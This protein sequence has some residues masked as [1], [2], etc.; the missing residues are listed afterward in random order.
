ME[1]P[2]PLSYS[3]VYDMTCKSNIDIFDDEADTLIILLAFNVLARNPFSKL[4]IYKP[5]TNV[6]LLLLCFYSKLRNITWFQTGTKKISDILTLEMHTRLFEQNMLK[7][8]LVSL[9]SL[10]V[11][12]HQSLIVNQ[13]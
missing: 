7:L 8:F 1:D 2:P 4:T 6:F 13:N 3:V 11:I 9:R 12:S 10:V 5:D